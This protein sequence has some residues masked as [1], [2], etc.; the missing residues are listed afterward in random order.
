MIG[1]GERRVSGAD[2]NIAAIQRA[3]ALRQVVT[4]I[5]IQSDLALGQRSATSQHQSVGVDVSSQMRFLAGGSDVTLD[6]NQSG[7]TSGGQESGTRQIEMSD[8]ERGRHRRRR[9]VGG[10]QRTRFALKLHL[11]AAR[12]SGGKGERKY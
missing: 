8:V 12:P 7:E 4:K 11:R 10:I 3:G 2:M 5:E 6:G 9:D 1:P